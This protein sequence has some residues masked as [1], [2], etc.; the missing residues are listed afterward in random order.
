MNPQMTPINADG[1]KDKTA[2]FVTNFRRS[3]PRL[4]RIG[5]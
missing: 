1:E 3:A 2:G 5:L 4:Q